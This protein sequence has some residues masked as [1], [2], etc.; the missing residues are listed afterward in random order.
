[1]YKMNFLKTTESTEDTEI[2][3]KGVVLPCFPWL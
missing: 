1:M 2:S 3:S